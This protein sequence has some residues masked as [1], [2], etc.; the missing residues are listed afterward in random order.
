MDRKEFWEM[1]SYTL[2]RHEAGSDDQFFLLERLLVKLSPQKILDF[3]NIKNQLMAEC[4]SFKMVIAAF[5]IFSDLSDELY[6][7]FRA[8]LILQGEARYTEAAADPDRIASWEIA[9]PENDIVGEGLHFV[10]ERAYLERT[11]GDEFYRRRR[12]VADPFFKD[13]WPESPEEFE[14]L[15]PAVYGRWF[16]EEKILASQAEDDDGSL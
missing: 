10:D 2:K 14:K 7:D 8:W 6:D 15:L 12:D 3:E 1:I 9:D 13:P 16:N 4:S 11:D 5:M